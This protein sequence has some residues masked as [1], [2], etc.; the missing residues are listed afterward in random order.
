MEIQ[1]GSIYFVSLR[2]MDIYFD[3]H[4]Y[5]LYDLQMIEYKWMNKCNHKGE[6]GRALR[7]LWPAWSLNHNTWQWNICIILDILRAMKMYD[8]YFAC[9]MVLM[10]ELVHLQVLTPLHLYNMGNIWSLFFLGSESDYEDFFLKRKKTCKHHKNG[11]VAIPF[12]YNYIRIIT[13]YMYWR[14][15]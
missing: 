12:I 7:A 5:C 14:K 4:F 11:H 6:L 15:N 10:Y 9:I 8:V 1:N 2:T 13:K 3:I